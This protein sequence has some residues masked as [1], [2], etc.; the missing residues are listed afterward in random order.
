[1]KPFFSFLLIAVLFSCKQQPSPLTK[2]TGNAMT[3]DFTIIVGDPLTSAQK[4]HVKE[5]IEAT[6]QEVDEIFNKWN[7]R[8]ELSQLNRLPAGVRM[9]LSPPLE[10]ILRFTQ[11]MV[12]L[13]QGKFDPTI[14]PLQ[15]LWKGALIQG[16]EPSQ[17]EIEKVIPS[18]GWEKVHLEGNEFYKDCDLTSLD[19]GGIAKGTCVDLLIEKLT[20]LGYSNIFV[21]WGG[22]IRAKGEHPDHRPWTIF[23]SRF[24]DPDPANAIATLPL[25]N[26]A[27]A[28]SGDYLQ[29]WTIR[30]RTTGEAK[31]YFH[32]IDPHAFR[33]LVA[34]NHSISSASVLAPNCTL[35]DSLA[36]IALFFSSVEEIQIWEKKLQEKYPGIRLWAIAKAL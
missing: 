8:S 10:K 12:E 14:E 34:T 16:R 31:T 13:S 7:P 19:L 27:I 11:E 20:V 4:D 5:V 21:E 26:Q 2:F 23:I 1:M 22:E 24:G 18:I 17:K 3:I 28:T 29:N 32:V 30:N 33:P 25:H 6:F 35:A 9:T 15:Q 36:T